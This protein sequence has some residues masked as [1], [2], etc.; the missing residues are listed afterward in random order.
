MLSFYLGLPNLR[1]YRNK[2]SYVFLFSPRGAKFPNHSIFSFFISLIFGA[3][4]KFEVSYYVIF[5]MNAHCVEELS[6][7]Y[8]LYLFP[9]QVPSIR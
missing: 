7:E 8:V 2:V 1:S 3:Q 6:L 5:E 4:Y 9:I